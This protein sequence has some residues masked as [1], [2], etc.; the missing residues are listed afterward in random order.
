VLA[1][2]LNGEAHVNG[3]AAPTPTGAEIRPT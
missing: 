1:L 2:P 3:A